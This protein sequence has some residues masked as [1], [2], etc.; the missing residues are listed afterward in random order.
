MDFIKD[1]TVTSEANS[2]TKIVGEIPFAELE[3]ERKKA[4]AHLGTNIE[5]DGF[6]KGHVPE[7]VLVGKIGEMSILTEMAERALARVYP[8]VLKEHTIEAIGHPEIQITK[9][10]PDN[11]LGFTATVAVMPEITLPD[12]EKIATEVNKNKES[13]AVTDEEVENQAKEIIRQ[14][15]AYERLQKKAAATPES[16]E[17]DLGGATELPTPESETSKAEEAAAQEPVKDDELPE[18]TDEYVKT[19]GQPGQFETVEDFKS[20]L[21]EHLTIEKERE[22]VAAH[23]GKITDQIIEET[24]VDL[25]QVLI[26]SEIGQMFG[27]MEE[28]LKRANLK[29]DDYLSH[30]KKSKEDLIEEWKP[31]AEKRAKLQLVLNEIAKKDNIEPDKGALD[32]QVDQLLEQYKDADEARVRVYVESVMTN[33]AVMQKLETM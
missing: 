21:R 7:E 29:M 8:E 17:K 9:I 22:T 13:A 14:K 5:L 30:I 18:L 2:Q 20:K 27:Q 28:D 6:R 4:I 32:E 33:E 3:K 25:P 26:D 15:E 1:F 19:L 10:A 23:R 11:P 16:E 24:K 31:A 12:Y